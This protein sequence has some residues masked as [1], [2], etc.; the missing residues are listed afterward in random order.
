MRLADRELD[1]VRR[2]M[3][4]RLHRFAEIL[5]A[6]Q[7]GGLVEEAVVDGDVE[8]APGGGIEETV[9]TI[10]FH[11]EAR[12]VGERTRAPQGQTRLPNQSALRIDKR[13]MEPAPQS[14]RTDQQ[15]DLSQP[16]AAGAA[17][18]WPDRCAGRLRLSLHEGALSFAGR[19]S[20]IHGKRDHLIVLGLIDVVM[21]AN[22][23]IMVIVG[24]YETFVSRLNLQ[25]IPISRSGCRM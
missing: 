20:E 9:E 5:D 15:F 11:A 17:L 2:R 23:L 12:R 18:F 4:Q 7:K 1:G 13:D 16:L 24:G 19:R 22:L 3:H 14:K 21:I 10:F 6:L 25:G 8:A